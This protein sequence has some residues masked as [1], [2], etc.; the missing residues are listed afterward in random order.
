MHT[1]IILLQNAKSDLERKSILV[2]A[3]SKQFSSQLEAVKKHH[4]SD[5][6]RMHSELQKVRGEGVTGDERG[7]EGAV[8]NERGRGIEA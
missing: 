7:W 2:V 5:L 4:E 1:Q 6:D 3:D 8:G